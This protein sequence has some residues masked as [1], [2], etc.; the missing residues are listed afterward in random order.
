MTVPSE[1]PH[2]TASQGKELRTPTWE[3]SFRGNL[4]VD[5]FRQQWTRALSEAKVLFKE[6]ETADATKPNEENLLRP[7]DRLISGVNCLTPFPFQRCH[8]DKAMRDEADASDKAC[9]AFVTNA[10]RSRALLDKLEKVDASPLDVLGKRFLER[11]IMSMK[12][13]GAGLDDKVRAELEVIQDRLTV[14]E[15]DFARNIDE[16]ELSMRV[17]EAELAGLPADF[18]KT[19]PLQ[20]DQ[21]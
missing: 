1:V 19:H 13:A 3:S 20:D 21:K 14:L 4:T 9:T 15:Q 17:T 18:F 12:R 10:F 2:S 7:L 5:E 11:S 6:L 8:P 16:G